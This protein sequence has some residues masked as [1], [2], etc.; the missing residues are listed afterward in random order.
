[1]DAKTTAWRYLQNLRETVLWKVEGLSERDQRMPLTPTGTNLLGVVKHLA[2]VE[3]GYFGV[4]LG[5]PWPEPLA[6]WHDDAEPNADMWATPEESPAMILDLYRRVTAFADET[7]AP[8]PLHAPA[9][10]PWWGTPDTDLHTLLV[11][12]AVETA[13]HA[14]QLDILREQLDGAIGMRE[15][16]SNL[17][18]ADRAWW[19]AYVDRLRGIAEQAP[20]SV[21]PTSG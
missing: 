3:S 19:D 9:S 21:P 7:I 18:D 4:C 2:A 5:R 8:L 1:M 6:S 12:M 10:V 16:V 17:P 15:G 20:A 13:R 11:H 14:G